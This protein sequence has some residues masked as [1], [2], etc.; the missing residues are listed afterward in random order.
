MYVN[1]LANDVILTLLVWTFDTQF[2]HLF[3]QSRPLQAKSLGGTATAAESPSS[4]FQHGLDMP[5][6]HILEVLSGVRFQRPW[7]RQVNAQ[8]IVLTQDHGM[9]DNI[10]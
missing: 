7:P 4:L 3:V 8:F 2:L 6:L 5:P 1:I 10:F 9:F